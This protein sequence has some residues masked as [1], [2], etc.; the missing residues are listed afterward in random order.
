MEDNS[1][2]GRCKLMF[3]VVASLVVQSLTFCTNFRK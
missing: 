1:S 2:V 3:D